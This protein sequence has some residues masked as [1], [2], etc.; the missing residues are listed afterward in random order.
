[1]N[2]KTE[3]LLII[4][5]RAL[6]SEAQACADRT[7]CPIRKQQPARLC[8]ELPTRNVH[9]R[10]VTR[11]HKLCVSNETNSYGIHKDHVQLQ[12]LSKETLQR[13]QNIE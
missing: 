3:V 8:V 11:Q 1:M 10:Y 4:S 13:S 5:E 6:L 7:F 12:I 9:N 2:L